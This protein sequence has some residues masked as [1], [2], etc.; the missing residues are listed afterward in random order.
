MVNNTEPIPSIVITHTSRDQKIEDVKSCA[1]DLHKLHNK[2][3]CK[4]Q[5][6]KKSLIKL[7]ENRFFRAKL[8][9]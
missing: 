6:Y 2:I 4:G 9:D 5:R 3:V 8:R 1:K 7:P